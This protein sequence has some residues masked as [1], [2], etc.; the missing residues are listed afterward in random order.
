MSYSRHEIRAVGQY[1]W[2]LRERAAESSFCMV[3]VADFSKCYNLLTIDEKRIVFKA[4]WLEDGTNANLILDWM[5][6][7]LNGS[8]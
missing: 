1:Y 4:I 6:D 2:N 3:R 8:N 7:F 5:C